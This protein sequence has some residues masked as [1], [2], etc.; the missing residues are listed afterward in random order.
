MNDKLTQSFTLDTIN[1]A[2][3]V[4]KKGEGV[5]GVVEY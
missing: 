2:F 5:R 3:A 4:M 1:D